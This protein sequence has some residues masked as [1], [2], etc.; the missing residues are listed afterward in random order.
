LLQ[1]ANDEAILSKN[2][3]L[4]KKI[5]NMKKHLLKK[6]FAFIVMIFFISFLNAQC[7]DNKVRLFKSTRSGACISKCVPQNQVQKYFD[8]GWRYSCNQVVYPLAK[9]NDRTQKTQSL[10]DVIDQ[11]WLLKTEKEELKKM[12]KKIIA[13]FCRQM[14]LDVYALNTSL[15]HDILSFLKLRMPK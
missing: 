9:S 13:L 5:N 15:L 6:L 12:N 7:P 14:T 8:Q 2:N 3:L 11:R 10:S 1:D 4:V